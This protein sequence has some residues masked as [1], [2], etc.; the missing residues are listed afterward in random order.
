MPDDKLYLLDTHILIWYFTGNQ[1]LKPQIRERIDEIRNRGGRLLIPTIV[2]AEALNIAEKDRVRFD[3]TALYR[4]LQEEP[5]FEI[6]G[7]GPEI[8]EETMRLKGIPEIHDRIIAATARFYGAGILTKD[9]II[10]ESG[11]VETI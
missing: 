4:L 8:L 11:E 10:C 2:L 7:F 5:E 6:V 3:F 9:R 1:R